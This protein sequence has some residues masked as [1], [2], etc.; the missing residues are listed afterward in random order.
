VRDQDVADVKQRIGGK[1]WITVVDAKSGYWQTP[2]KPEDRWLTA[3]VYNDGLYQFCRTP[4]GLKSSGATFV[5][6]LKNIL[7]PINDITDSYVDDIATFSDEWRQHLVD[8]E[9]FLQTISRAHITLNIK[10]CKFAQHQVKFCGEFVGSGQRKI[11]P[12][13]VEVIESIQAPTTKTELRQI[14]GL[15][16]FFREYIP[17]YAEVV[18]SLTDLTKKNVPDQLPWSHIHDETLAKL[19]QALS[20]AARS[21]LTVVDFSKPYDIF[22][23]ASEKAV[24]GILTQQDTKK[25]YAPIAFFSQKLN[26]TQRKWSTVEREAYAVIVAL[27]KYRSW[28]FRSVVRVHSDHNPLTYI[29]DTAPRSAKLMRWALGLQEFQ[30]EFK[31]RK[32][33]N[34][35]AADCL[36]RLATN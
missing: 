2:V 30:V 22:V 31:Y 11:D 29:T 9:R 33:T 25:Q 32:G 6:A 4:F 19:K 13:K 7:Q 1:Q 35:L 23:D 16:S 14:L 27:R 26:D 15:F 24:S 3:F 8:L 5:R 12:S 20:E 18:L 34:N 17:R 10:K 21:N 28:L 36:S